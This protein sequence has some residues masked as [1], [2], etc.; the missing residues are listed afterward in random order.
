MHRPPTKL[1]LDYPVPLKLPVPNLPEPFAQ[2][3]LALSILDYLDLGELGSHFFG[4]STFRDYSEGRFL[5]FANTN[6]F[7][8]GTLDPFRRLILCRP[9]EAACR[10]YR[11][12]RGR[13]F[14]A[15]REALP[16]GGTL[17]AVVREMARRSVRPRSS[18]P[19]RRDFQLVA[20]REITIEPATHKVLHGGQYLDLEPGEWLEIELELE[21]RGEAG[22]VK[23]D[24]F[25]TQT[26]TWAAKRSPGGM[27]ALVRRSVD[28][29]DGQTLHWKYT[30]APGEAMKG[31]QS[32]STVRSRSN[33]PFELIFKTARMSVRWAGDRPDEK[34]RTEIFEITPAT[35]SHVD[36]RTLDSRTEPDR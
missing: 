8:V 32:R 26:N 30:I 23:I 17:D 36:S 5:Y 24:H 25:T 6:H 31:L 15:R 10:R 4:R 11:A 29:R 7:M 18:D 1:A 20:E 35:A 2:A 21:A 33:A 16:T 28:L 13:I 34:I 12:D 14:G 19:R 22:F 27:P 9:E 3:D